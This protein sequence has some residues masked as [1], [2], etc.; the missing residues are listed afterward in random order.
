MKRPPLFFLLLLNVCWLSAQQN[1]KMQQND[2]APLWE[3]VS[4]LEKKS[5][6]Q[7]A[8]EKV[9]R[10]LHRAVSEQ[11]TPQ[12]I[13]AVIHLGKYDLARDAE[14]DTVVFS[15]L[16]GMLNESSDAVERALLHSMLGE[17]YLQYYQRDQWQ[18]RQRTEL[19]GYLPSDMKEWSRNNFYDRV[20][21]HLEASLAEKEQLLK[22]TVSAYAA[23]VDE[24]KDSRRYYPT[25]YD[26]LARRAIE[27]YRQLESNEDLSRTLARRELAPASLFAPAKAFIHLPLD[28]KK[29][30]YNL[31]A[32]ET[33]RKLMAS[34]LERGLRQSLLLA[35]LDKLE[36]L[37]QLQETYRLYALP[38]LEAMLKEWEGDPF[39][40]EIIN[41]IAELRQQELY[42]VSEHSDSLRNEKTE[43]LYNFLKGAVDKYPDYKRI[44]LLEKRLQQLTSPHFSFSGNHTFPKDGVKKITVTF[45]NLRSLKGMLYRIDSPVDLQKHQLGILQT[46]NRKRTFV[47]EIPVKLP[48]T[49]P[50]LEGETAIELN[51]SEPGSYMLTFDSQPETND[52][53]QPVYFFAVSDLSLF[54]RTAGKGLH[55]FF[56]V[57]RVTGR[58]VEDAVV[59]LYNYSG[60]WRNARLTEAS[61]VTTNRDGL[62]V[63]R[64]NDPEEILFFHAIKGADSGSL[65]SRPGSTRYFAVTGNREEREQIDIFTDRSLY[66]P[67]QTVYYKAVMTREADSKRSLVR[68]RK[69]EVSLH[70]A[71][72]EKIASQVGVTNEFGSIAGEFVLPQGLLT[73]HFSLRTESGSASIRVEEYKRPT[74]EVTFDPVEGSYRF[75]EEVTL[76][77]KTLAYSGVPLQG[78]TVTYR[79]TRQQSWWRFR[80]GV[81][82]PFAEGVETSDDQGRFEIRFTPEKSDTEQGKQTAF[83]FTVE[84]VVTDLN[85][86]TQ[87]GSYALSVGDVSMMLQLELAERWEKESSDPIFISAKNLN[88]GD[89]KA[90][91]SYVVYLLDE[92]DSIVREVAKGDFETGPQPGLKKQLSLLRSGR[93]QV[94]LLSKDDRGNPVEAEKDLILFSFTDKR[95][96]VKTNDWFVVRSSTFTPRKPAE[97]LLGV[98]DKIHLLYELWK[99][100][101]L[102]ERRWLTLEN[103]N[104]RFSFPYREEYGEGVTLMLTYVKDQQFYS[105]HT[106]IL[107]EEE[108]EELQVK[109]DLF[110]DRIRPGSD[111]EWRITVTDAAGNPAAAELLASMYDFSLD[112][113]YPSP[114]WSFPAASFSRY[115][116]AARLTRD[117]SFSSVYGRGYIPVSWKEVPEFRF[118]RFN[119][120]GFSFY[121]DLVLFRTS[122]AK[123]EDSAVGGYG[124]VRS[125]MK[126]AESELAEEAKEEVMAGESNVAPPSPAAKSESD[127]QVRRHFNETA[128][129]YPQLRTNEKGEVQIA[130]SV[131]ESNTRWRFRLLAHDRQ[132]RS[133]SS[134]SFTVSQ[135]ELMVTPNMPRFFR[136]GDSASISTKI[137]NLSDSLLNG[138][139]RLEL[140][141]PLTEE[142]IPEITLVD[143]VKPF[144]L[145]TGASTDASWGFIVPSGIELL[146][147]RIVAETDLFSDG[148]Q[149]ALAVLPSRMLVTESMHMDLNSG[150]TKQFT[151]ERL[152]EHSSPTTEEYRLT[153]EF[154]SSPAWYALQALP[155]LS[156]PVQDNAVDWFAACYSTSLGTHIGKSYPRVTAMVDAWQKEGGTGESLQSQL[157]KNEELKNLL[158]EETP[159]VL[160]ARD[161]S[162]QLQRLS[163]LF[164]LNHSRDQLSRSV[165]RLQELQTHEGGWSWFK[166]FRPS[167]GITHYILYGFS[168]LQALGALQPGE[169][170][171]AMQSKAIEFADAEA[172]RRFTALKRYNK[173]WKQIRMISLT[174]LEY[175][176][177]RTAYEDRPMDEEVK[178]MTGFYRSVVQKHWTAYGLY[179]RSLIAVL[180]HRGRQKEV[181]QSIL[182]SFREHATQSEEMGMYWANNRSR[183]F[184]SQS[185]I[186]VHTFIMDAFRLGGASAV[187]TDQMKRW[188]LKQKQTQ[189]W[190]STHATTDAVYA[191]LSGGSDW[192]FATGE[193]TV[194]VGDKLVEPTNREAGTGYFKESWNR[195]EIT[196]VMGVVTVEHNGSGPA[197]GA[198]YRQYFEEVDKV[199]KSDGSLDIEKQLFLEQTDASGRVLVPLTEER[200]LQVGDR[201]VVRLTLRNDRD[202]EFVQLKDMRA[203]CFEPVTQLSGMTWQNGVP[204]YQRTKD[205]STSFFFDQLPRGTRVFEYALYVTRAGSYSG[206][207]ATVQSLYAPAFIS[208]TGGMRIIVKE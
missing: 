202:L 152:L 159:W 19:R 20:V 49:P 121:N 94:K 203:A 180:M 13:K 53:D 149:H 72:G 56:V 87:T 6:P 193:T 181:V 26:F 200:S 86:E 54:S 78:A 66:R 81:P 136:E 179:E 92:R 46:L 79:I 165:R 164:D 178:E 101:K 3:E 141:D 4:A 38:S 2:Y 201:V 50:Y 153:L 51:L 41:Q 47:M 27:Q 76:R 84:A 195:T 61:S 139:V 1:I 176:Y 67:G 48:D 32:Y 124:S 204:C 93:Y 151:M 208:H 183:V 83:T 107:R 173:D 116:S 169:E 119:W 42:R 96:P 160:D 23:V 24:G 64:S 90:E 199:V 115:R 97:I 85:G 10:I 186:S 65:L 80:G 31:M 21:E 75:G 69:I 143:A 137:S 68:E 168:R 140:F 158:L 12:V 123:Q 205:A 131:P 189:Q 106:D 167:V 104:R 113:I 157:N 122:S 166:G 190:E 171:L 25:M 45:K 129:F 144:T 120:H 126:V 102:L 29:G 170:I 70:D 188:L 37:A 82:E 40:V 177:V 108:K 112:Q 18:I 74:F 194:K 58:P 192:F 59:V 155:V 52:N 60:N 71:N 197:W 62:A 118:D 174:D 77:G 89:V 15:R 44:A 156:N 57:D 39:S 125:Q 36:S 105:H 9:N 17:L 135:K 5:L 134:E 91:G 148:E 109:L 100:E 117:N 163:L 14:N 63:Y 28:P 196:P 145:A 187:E 175:L 182:R 114:A 55:H 154:A 191:L 98:T 88:G 73:G 11:N 138:R 184:M 172:V 34:L 198:L 146:G 103:E 7:S 95:P 162:E 110:R 207:I 99:E 43:E 132:L 8:A 30:E 35:E 185:A 128:F 206:G 161:E 142:V 127:L 133:G 130:F 22:A 147:V 150:E 33:W 111:E 16:E